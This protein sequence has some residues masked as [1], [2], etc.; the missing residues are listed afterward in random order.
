MWRFLLACFGGKRDAARCIAG[1]LPT[2]TTHPPQ[3]RI[4]PP[5][6]SRGRSLESLRLA[7]QEAVASGLPDRLI[8]DDI[9]PRKLEAP[10]PARAAPVEAPEVPLPEKR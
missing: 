4:H 6:A 3:V 5:I 9:R 2:S 1:S 7:A 10:N 8:G